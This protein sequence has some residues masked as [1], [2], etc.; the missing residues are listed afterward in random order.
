MDTES[1]DS[2]VAELNKL[3]KVDLINIII[4]K[5][6]PD[7]LVNSVTQDIVTNLMNCG[8]QLR[9]NSE[10]S[11]CSG[12]ITVNRSADT[13]RCDKVACIKTQIQCDYTR[14]F[15]DMKQTEVDLLKQRIRDL[16]I[17]N[18]LLKK[19]ANNPVHKGNRSESLSTH[20]NTVAAGS[21]A[22]QCDTGVGKSLRMGGEFSNGKRT[23]TVADVVQSGQ[24]GASGVS[25]V[26][27]VTLR[28][29]S[30]AVERA[31]KVGNSGGTIA[32]S[33]TPFVPIIGTN[34]VNHSVKSVPRRGYIHVY[35]VSPEVGPEDLARYLK[36]AA[37]DIDFACKE[38][39]KDETTSSF[40][41]DFSIKHLE[42][43]YNPE[44]WPEGVAI[45]RYYFPRANFRKHIVK[46]PAD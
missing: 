31:K 11:D 21:S 35:R 41:V 24:S 16:E 3:R 33:R 46:Q 37:P 8:L 44:I 34:N 14:Q 17:I 32:G 5:K 23:R 39:R 2:A 15:V 18:D 20:R 19:T 22:V 12:E 36:L 13:D 45:K 28:A 43:A 25:A 4:Y 1:V 42:G 27:P 10:E 40:V 7:S 6:W 29:V 38:L 9:E 30:D 26:K